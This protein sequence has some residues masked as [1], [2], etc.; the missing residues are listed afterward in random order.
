MRSD[1]FRIGA[2]VAGLAFS[3][4]CAT[5][6]ASKPIV[7]GYRIDP[8]TLEGVRVIAQ[9]Y[10]GTAQIVPRAD[11][12]VDI[13]P[14]AGSKPNQLYLQKALHDADV[15]ADGEVTIREIN[16]LATRV[17]MQYR[18]NSIKQQIEEKLREQR[19]EQQ[20]DPKEEGQTT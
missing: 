12:G 6:S 20:T 16:D 18:F 14:G 3:S 7:E 11:G 5:F 1:Y 15:D 9:M 8:S 4:S 19:R 10:E 17:L 13:L 2:V